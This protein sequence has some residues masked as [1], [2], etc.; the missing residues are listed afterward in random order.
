VSRK[1]ET[2][3][4]FVIFSTKLSYFHKIW[5]TISSINLLKNDIN[6]FHLSGVMSLHYL[7][8]LKM[9]IGHALHLSCY[10]KKLQN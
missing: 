8:K 4:F 7:V 1:K 5:Y 9:L 10:R 3:C 6:V 2:K